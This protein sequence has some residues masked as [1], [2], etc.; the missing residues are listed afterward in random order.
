MKIMISYRRNASRHRF[1]TRKAEVFAKR[2]A[3]MLCFFAQNGR[4]ETFRRGEIAFFTN[5]GFIR[6]PFWRP[7]WGQNRS[8][9]GSILGIENRF[10]IGPYK[11]AKLPSTQRSTPFML[12]HFTALPVIRQ[13]SNPRKSRTPPSPWTPSLSSISS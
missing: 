9:L 2:C 7:F 11:C 5:L 13:P 3:N 12:K 1:P 4:R 8:I 6:G 10:K